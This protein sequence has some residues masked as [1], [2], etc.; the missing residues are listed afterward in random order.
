MGA[1]RNSN[2]RCIALRRRFRHTDQSSIRWQPLTIPEVVA[3]PPS[4]GRSA[5]DNLPDTRASFG[6]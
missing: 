5:C 3:A 6:G 1:A 4:W 2:C